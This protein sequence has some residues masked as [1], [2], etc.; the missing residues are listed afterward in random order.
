MYTSE[1]SQAARKP[2]RNSQMSRNAENKAPQQENDQ[3]AA[4]VPGALSTPRIHAEL[5]AS[6]AMLLARLDGNPAMSA[7]TT[8]RVPDAVLCAPVLSQS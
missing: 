6:L 8:V 4:Q 1:S 7:N 3:S 5:S 2:M